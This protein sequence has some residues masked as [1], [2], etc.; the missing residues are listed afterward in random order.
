LTGQ[1]GRVRRRTLLLGAAAL[2][3]LAAAAGG[4]RTALRRTR[5]PRLPARGAERPDARQRG[6]LLALLPV[7]LPEG[8]APDEAGLAALLDAAAR[9][10]PRLHAAQREAAGLL[11]RR[12][13]RLLGVSFAAA[14]RAGREEV[15][16]SCLWSF[17][18]GAP[19]DR[20][21]LRGRMLSRLER[22]F[23]SPAERRFREHVVRRV[24]VA[25]YRGPRAWALVGQRNFP[26]V[27]GDPRAYVNAPSLRRNEDATPA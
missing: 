17:P 2:G 12:S 20:T 14:D 9:D 1:A 15:V 8:Q 3:G 26:G 23:Q 16:R 13:R 22:L 24:L 18:G 7:L 25:F 11:E 27:P 6:T 5:K 19:G 21:L 4:G 10:E